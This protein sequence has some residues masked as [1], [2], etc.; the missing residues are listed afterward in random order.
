MSAEE[1]QNYEE[2]SKKI[3]LD[4]ETAKQNIEKTKRELKNARTVRRNR[5]EYDLLAT[6]I[7]QQP[8]RRKTNEELAQ[9]REDLSA[10]QV[11]VIL[12]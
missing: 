5:I 12:N 10:L 9:L 3:D 2:W 6:V 11:R 8:D 1:L 4:I 7:N